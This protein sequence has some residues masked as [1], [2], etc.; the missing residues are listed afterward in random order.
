MSFLD[1]LRYRY[2]LFNA[3]ERLI[4]LIVVCFILPFI[5]DT[6]LFLMDLPRGTF[7]S[8]FELR[9]E[10]WSL[11]YR[12]WTF[13]TYSFFH[14]G[15]F[16]LFWNMLLLY[17]MGQF[18]LN[19]FKPS[20][21]YNVYFLGVLAGGLLFLLSYRLFP[22][23]SLQTPPL[24]GASAGVMAVLIFMATYS[25]DQII[26]LF[27]FN[28]PLKYLAIGFVVLD[29]IQIPY[30]NAGGHL[31]HLGGAGLGFVYARQLLSGK[32]IGTGFENLWRGL[33]Q[34]F[35]P[36]PLKTVYKNTSASAPKKDSYPDQASIDKILDKISQSGYDSLSAKEKEILFKAGKK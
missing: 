14:A 15:F 32:D 30:G 34:M 33:V 36:K 19:L 10:W 9:P 2:N 1:D 20:M 6:L 29:I 13:I 16:H 8:W 23:F 22:A 21:F 3:A 4:S 18:L 17:Y 5:L 12:P 7:V 28:I 27:I 11:L 26:R 31:A 25:P 35:R 24:I